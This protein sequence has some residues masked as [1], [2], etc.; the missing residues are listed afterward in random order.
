MRFLRSMRE[1]N[2]AEPINSLYEL[3]YKNRKTREAK[4]PIGS[5]ASL[6]PMI[7]ISSYCFNLNHFHFLLLQKIDKGIEKFMHRIGTGYT[8]YFNQKYNRSGSLFQ[9]TYKAI[10]VNDYG[11][12]LK[13]LVYVNCNHEIHNLGKAENWPWASYLDSV[14]LRRGNLCNMDAVREEF[15]ESENFKN[16]CREIIPE[17]KENKVLKKYLLE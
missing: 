3:D 12:L 11:Y 6:C 5:L 1:F 17:I 13:L 9:G 8:K 10:H 7:E 15:G 4:L 16:F 2:G 14:G